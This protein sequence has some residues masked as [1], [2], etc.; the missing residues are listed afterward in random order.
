MTAPVDWLMENSG[1][2]VRWRT[3]AELGGE[4]TPETPLA[5]ELVAHPLVC[6]WLERLSFAG[7]DTPL[8]ALD[9]PA[10]A[11]LGQMVHGAKAG[12]LENV[13]GK[14]AELGLR[15]GMPE[16][17]RRP[18][19]FALF[20]W[21]PVWQA[22]GMYQNAWETLVKSI[23]AWGL[24]RL[25][26]MPDAPMADY[27]L[28]HLDVCHKAAR[29]RVYDIYAGEAEAAGLPKAWAGKPIL[30]QEVM[31]N[32]WLPY[33]HD[34]YVFAHFP[35]ALRDESTQRKIDD[36]IDYVLD[37]RFQ[38][39]REGYGY[40]WVKDKR[41]GYSWGWSPHFKKDAALVQRVELLARFARARE[42]PLFTGLLGYL[43]SFA[44][45][46][47]FYRFPP[48]YLRE[49]EG[50]YV[51]GSGMGLGEPRRSPGWNQVESTFRMLKIKSLL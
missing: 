4:A 6:Q 49:T 13:F 23:F 45:G 51:L 17:D 46:E 2:V 30:R 44:V 48:E 9:A 8:D 19:P 3:A 20:R 29:D 26:Y 22:A 31:E 32:Y 21:R 40:A 16:L 35:A 27:L 33:I 43:E 28:E 42:H 38:A 10:L 39:L 18:L 15:A 1:P 5:R 50:Y 24:L 41:T 12:C 25:G 47:G 14:L 36:L 7:F 37:P 11:R 34:L